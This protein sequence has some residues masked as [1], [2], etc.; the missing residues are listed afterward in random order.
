MTRLWSSGREI[1]VETDAHGHV[2]SFTWQGR[3]WKIH[4]VYQRWQV[5]SDWWSAEGH[6]QREYLALTTT[7]G[8]LCVLYQD[9]LDE[10]WYLAKMYD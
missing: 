10:R 8:L 4:Q 3:K 1:T 9:L 6:A 7:D 2:R 5:D